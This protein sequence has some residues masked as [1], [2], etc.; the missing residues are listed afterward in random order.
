MVRG[1]KMCA[2]QRHEEAWC[3]PR[4]TVTGEQR[5]NEKIMYY[6]LGSA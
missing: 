3:V 5:K 4:R 6:L 2:V 1:R